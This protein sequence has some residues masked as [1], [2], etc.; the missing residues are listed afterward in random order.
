LVIDKTRDAYY[1]RNFGITLE[2]YN[3]RLLEQNGACACCGWIPQS[4]QVRLAVDHEHFK[5]EVVPH[6]LDT[7]EQQKE[8]GWLATVQKFGVKEWAKTKLE[9]VKQ[10]K[11]QAMPL[12]VRGLL[13]MFCNRFVLGACGRHPVK[14]LR[15]NP[16]L[17]DRAKKYLL[18]YSP[19]S[20]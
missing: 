6:F 12:S 20:A 13:C 5:V 1:R 7:G 8:K 15:D 17:F 9:A 19:K 18:D 14:A 10:A 2:D 11:K 3:R 4:G 16:E